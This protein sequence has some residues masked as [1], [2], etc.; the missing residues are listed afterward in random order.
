M[1]LFRFPGHS[2]HDIRWFRFFNDLSEEIWLQCDWFQ[3]VPRCSGYTVG[4]YRA[5]S[6]RTGGWS[7]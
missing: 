3:S 6:L 2:C 4:Y 1:S 5:W 7:N